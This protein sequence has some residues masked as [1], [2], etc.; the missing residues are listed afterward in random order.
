MISF[1]GKLASVFQSRVFPKTFRLFSK[2]RPNSSSLNQEMYVVTITD[3]ICALF[4]AFWS[5]GNR[6]SMQLSYR[7]PLA[8]SSLPGWGWR[9]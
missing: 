8:F 9:G 1:S 6:R 3:A 5:L 2:A 4:F 7:D